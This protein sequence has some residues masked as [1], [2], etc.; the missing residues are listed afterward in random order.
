VETIPQDLVIRATIAM[1]IFVRNLLHF[2]LESPF[3]KTIF[4]NHD[5]INYDSLTVFFKNSRLLKLSAQKIVSAGKSLK[6]RSRVAR[7]FVTQYTKA[8]EN[9]PNGLKM[10]QMA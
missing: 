7:F 3:Y 2:E 10:Y 1:F 4:A 9:I 5:D 8:G 6:I